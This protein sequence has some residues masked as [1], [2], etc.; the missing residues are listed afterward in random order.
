MAGVGHQRW[1]AQ[2]GEHVRGRRHLGGTAYRVP[3]GAVSDP[4]H[5]GGVG[6]G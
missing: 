2:L 3:A 5:D 6:R 4:I 1:H